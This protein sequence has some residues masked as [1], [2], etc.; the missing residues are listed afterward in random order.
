MEIVLP[1]LFDYQP[2]I[3]ES[4]SQ[5]TSVNF[6]PERRQVD[7]NNFVAGVTS[8]RPLAGTRHTFDCIRNATSTEIFSGLQAAIS[9]APEE[10]AFDPT[11][12]GPGGLYP[13]IPSR[14]LT[15]GN[16]AQLPFIS[17]TNLDE[18]A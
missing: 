6:G 3:F 4:G 12:D 15:R 17:G 1:T 14:L 7:W 11:I 18:G 9:K 2:Q 16:F 5:A 10:F 13:D 8:C